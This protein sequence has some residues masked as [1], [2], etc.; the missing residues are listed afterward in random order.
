V[1]PLRDLS[2]RSGSPAPWTYLALFLATSLLMIW[3]LEAMLDHGLEGTALGTV[4]MPYC[5]ASATALRRNHP[6]VMAR[7]GGADQLP[8]QQCHQ[9]HAPCWACPRGWGLKLGRMP[10][11]TR[12]API[13]RRQK[14][15]AGGHDIG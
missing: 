5:S 1:N 2:R 15:P 9:P 3:R 8:R 13:R 6:A 11:Q 10:R 7:E 14:S 4:V 12:K